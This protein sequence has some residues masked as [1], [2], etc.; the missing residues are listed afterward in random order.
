MSEQTTAEV[1]SIDGAASALDVGLGDTVIC[2][3]DEW[4]S[5]EKTDF[6]CNVTSIADDGIDVIYLSGYRSRNDFVPWADVLAKLDKRA[7]RVSVPGTSYEG[8]FVLA[9]NG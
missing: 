4:R 6:D 8:H 2:L 1:G 5:G 7:A 9:P 3:I